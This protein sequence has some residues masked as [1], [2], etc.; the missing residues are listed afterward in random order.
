M[1]WMYGLLAMTIVSSSWATPARTAG[2]GISDQPWMVSGQLPYIFLN[3]A[4]LAGYRDQAFFEHS[5]SGSQGGIFA[6]LGDTI[7]LG[8][9]SGRPVNSS[10]LNSGSGPRGLFDSA[11]SD[12]LQQFNSTV[13]AALD[14]SATTSGLGNLGSRVNEL[15]D[16][17]ANPLN[18]RQVSAMLGFDLGTARLGLLSELQDQFKSETEVALGLAFDIGTTIRSVDLALSITSY[19]LRNSYEASNTNGEIVQALVED[20]G[21][22]DITLRNRWL[23]Q[24]HKEHNS[25]I[26]WQVSVLDSSS[27]DKTISRVTSFTL[28]SNDTYSRTGVEARFGLANELLLDNTTRVIAGTELQWFYHKNVYDGQ[29]KATKTYSRQ[30]YAADYRSLRLP[31]VLALE[32]ALSENWQIRFSLVQYLFNSP[33]AGYNLTQVTRTRNNTSLPA[34]DNEVAD[35]REIF[36]NPATNL[37]LGLSYTIGRLRLDWLTKVAL[38]REGPYFLSGKSNEVSFSVAAIYNFSAVFSEPITEKEAP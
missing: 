6:G 23:L 2:L 1:R 36:A 5:D 21:A 30:P 27:I 3:P 22:H 37:N 19:G 16:P 38:F 20:A 9:L 26:F 17:G 35:E 31:L 18:N 13:G 7:I 32:T 29:D 34:V 24:F 33:A 10:V 8:I 28:D 25:T 12:Y 15:D 4:E 11:S 14:A